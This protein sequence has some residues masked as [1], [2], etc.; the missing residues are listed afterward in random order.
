MKYCAPWQPAEL[1]HM[2]A[3][4]SNGNCC[5]CAAS[6]EIIWSGEVLSARVVYCAVLQCVWL[7]VPPH[8]GS[9]G[10]MCRTFYFERSNDVWLC[11]F[12]L[13]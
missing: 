13:M 8:D 2:F 9:H 4:C 5:S 10:V 1:T 11:V 12:A 6:A 3:V 7:S